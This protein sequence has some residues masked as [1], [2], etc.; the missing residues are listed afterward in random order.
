MDPHILSFAKASCF[1]RCKKRVQAQ[2]MKCYCHGATHHGGTT[3]LR[4]LYNNDMWQAG[5]WDSVTGSLPWSP[6]RWIRLSDS[7]GPKRT[8]IPT[9]AKWLWSIA[10]LSVSETAP[11]IYLVITGRVANRLFSFRV[12]PGWRALNLGSGASLLQ[13]TCEWQAQRHWEEGSG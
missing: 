5:C 2:K 4:M 7:N 9:V 6:K 13:K 3:Q 11:K 1:S 10:E 12:T 8:L